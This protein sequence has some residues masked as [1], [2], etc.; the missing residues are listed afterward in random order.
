[1][2]LVFQGALYVANVGDSRAVLCQPGT[3]L[4]VRPLSE[5]HTVGNEKELAR[6]TGLGL[7]ESWLKKTGRL[8]P[9]E[10]TR[11]IGDY[12]I[13]GGYKEMVEIR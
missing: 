12:S 6:L 9:C 5:D 4:R 3:T 7:S 13:K 11:C 2:A 10:I 8:G 1:M